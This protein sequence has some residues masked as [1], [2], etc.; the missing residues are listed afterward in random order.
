VILGHLA[1]LAAHRTHADA[2]A[3]L[4]KRLRVARERARQDSTEE[5]PPSKVVAKLN[6]WAPL[7]AEIAEAHEAIDTLL[8]ESIHLQLDAFAEQARRLTVVPAAPESSIDVH[9]LRIAGKALR[10]T[11]EMAREQG[12]PLAPAVLRTFKRMQEALGLW[13]DFVVLTEWAMRASLDELLAHHDTA[14]QAKVF[15]LARLTLGRSERQL[16]RFTD[17]WV[18]E[19]AG[20]AET[21]RACFPLTKSLT[22]PETDPGPSATAET[23]APAAPPQ[24]AA[25]AA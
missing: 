17:L 19:G 12:R 24:G 9:E 18:R 14:M 11:L 15:A 20:L 3:W 7:R 4:S 22:P 5:P 25:P 1:D 6:A 21:I 10:Y 2:V 23:P 13:H 16:K 8:V